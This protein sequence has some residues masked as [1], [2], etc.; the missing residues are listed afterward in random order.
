AM[1]PGAVV[2][3]AVLVVLAICL[4]VLVVVRDEIVEREAVVRGD[5]VDARPGLASRPVEDLRRSAK[6]R[7][8][9]LRRGLRAPEVAHRVAELVVPLRP[10]R[11]KAPELVA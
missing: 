11:R 5:E 2:G 6:A 8:Q 3:A 1:V 7:R 4:V 10:A 9:R